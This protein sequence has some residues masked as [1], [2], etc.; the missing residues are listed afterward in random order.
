M[1]EIADTRQFVSQKDVT[2]DALNQRFRRLYNAVN[3]L[4]VRSIT[5]AR[6]LDVTDDVVLCDASGAAFTVTLPTA[7]RIRGRTYTVKK[8]DSSGNA[9][10]IDGA[11]TETIDGAATVALSTQNAFRTIVSNGTNWFVISS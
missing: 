4:E 11:G 9:V 2:P 5:A 8:T 1:G 6:T 10:T 7:A 3:R